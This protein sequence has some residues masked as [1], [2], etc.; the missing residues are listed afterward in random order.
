[1]NHKVGVVGLGFGLGVHVP[2]FRLDSRC[3]VAAICASTKERAAEAAEKAGL[4][5]SHGD[6]RQLVADSEIDIVSIATPAGAQHQIAR[7]A[8]AAGKHVFLEKPLA[9]TAE[10][11]LELAALAESNGVRISL[12]FEFV[13]T[14]GWPELKRAL[15]AGELGD[16]RIVN[17]DWQVNSYAI[18]NGFFDSWK[19]RPEMDGG[20]LNL[21]GTHTFHYLEWLFGP[22]RRLRAHLPG[23]PGLP[24]EV[25]AL[26][27]L[28][29]EFEN[30]AAGSVSLSSASFQ[31]NGHRLE[32]YGS[33]GCAR[34]NNSTKD[35]IRGFELDIGSAETGERRTIPLDQDDDLERDGRIAPVSRMV[36]RF[37]DAIDAGRACS[38]NVADGVRVQRWIDV[39]R[40]SAKSG[41]WLGVSE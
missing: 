9:S 31:G 5:A 32:V 20:V 38:P 37:V 40:E 3:E 19:L 22:I 14:P 39:A 18:Q 6:W 2:A 10:Q 13:E 28:Q 12:D 34:L 35:Y 7:G 25:E 11:G 26:A 21:F 16:L 30:G 23:L 36:R 41:K 24:S 8:M 29:I 15:D 17:L 4:P 1:M 33:N 27:L